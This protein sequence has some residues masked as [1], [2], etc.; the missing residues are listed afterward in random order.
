[1][2]R[3]NIETFVIFFAVDGVFQ[4]VDI[5]IEIENNESDEIG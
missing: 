4:V 3:F 5:N 1:M 2:F